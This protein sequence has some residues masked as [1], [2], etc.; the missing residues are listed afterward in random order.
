MD[1][2][3]ADVL[4]RETLRPFD[5]ATGPLCRFTLVRRPGG[6]TLIVV[7]HHI[8]FDGG[9]KD[10]LVH[11]L[12]A[13]YRGMLDSEPVPF[14]TDEDDRLA[15]ALP[16]AREFW[17]EHRHG[18]ADLVLPGLRHGTDEPAAGSVAVDLGGRLHKPRRRSASPRSNC[19]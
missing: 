14:V 1:G 12:A 2:D 10:V 17:S 19:C 4:R 3:P 15:S 7:A 13:G 11:D 9:S 18:H 8:V 16:A 6:V 5:V